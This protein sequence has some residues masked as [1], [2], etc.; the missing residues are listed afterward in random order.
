MRQLDLALRQATKDDFAELKAV[1]LA[2]FETLRAVGAVAGEP[3]ASDDEVLQ[4]YLDDGLLHV[5]FDGMRKIVGFCGGREIGG[6]LHIAEMDVHPDWQRRGIGRRLMEAVLAEGRR[7]SLRGATL[8]TD[9][10]APFNAPFYA[11]LGFD[12]PAQGE[13]PPHLREI[14]ETEIRRS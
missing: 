8:T 3:K 6:W 4:L 5:A 12:V 10:V 11:T 1:E 7:R 2:A 13:V 9:R 14:L